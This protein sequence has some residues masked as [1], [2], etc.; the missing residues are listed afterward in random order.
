M[1]APRDR[2]P[3]VS[4]GE[5]R[6]RVESELSGS[7]LGTALSSTGSEGFAVEPLFTDEHPSRSKSPQL[8]LAESLR[9]FPRPRGAAPGGADAPNREICQFYGHDDPTEVNRRLREGLDGGATGAWLR[10]GTGDTTVSSLRDFRVAT[11]GLPVEPTLWM[12]SVE[13]DLGAAASLALEA[14]V[15]RLGERGESSVVLRADPVQISVNAALSSPVPTS[16]EAELARIVGRFAD[17][18]PGSRSIVVSSPRLEPG[19]SDLVRELGVGI[20]AVA[21]YLDRMVAQGLD[22]ALT[23]RQ[24][25]WTLAMGREIFPEIAKLRAA[26]VLWRQL[27][28]SRGVVSPSRPWLHAVCGVGGPDPKPEAW[29]HL[30][31]GTTAAFAAIAGGADA[32]TTLPFED[33]GTSSQDRWARNTQLIL[34]EESFL[35]EVLDPGGGSYYLDWLTAELAERAW[36]N[37]LEIE[38]HGGIE[39]FFRESR[40]L[41]DLP[42]LRKRA[43]HGKTPIDEDDDI[44]QM[45]ALPIESVDVV[46]APTPE[47]ISRLPVYSSQDLEG[48]PYTDTMPGFAPFIR[49]PYPTMY[50]GRP[51]TIRQYAGFSTAEASNAFYRRNLAGGQKGLSIAFDL[52]THRGYDS[53]HPRVAGDVGMAGVAI[54]SILDMRILF[55]GIPLDKM[56]VSMTMNGAVLPVMALYIVAAEEQGVSADQLSGTIQNDILKEFMVRNTYIYPPEQSM[57]IVRDIIAFSAEHMPRFNS[58]SISGYHMQEAGA[59]ADLELAYTLADGLE[60]VRTGLGAGLGIDEFAPRLSFFFGIGMDYFMEVA[61][62]RA[63]RLLWAELIQ[64]FEPRDSRSLMLRTHCQTSGWSLSA[65]DVFNNVSRTCIE[66][67]AAVHGQTQSL[68]TNSFDEA[69]ALPTDFSARIARDTQI[70]LQEESGVCRVIDPWGGS[71]YVE[72]LT[73]QIAERARE[74]IAEVE[75]MGGMVKAIEAGLPKLRIEEAA[76]R[77]QA[78]IDSGRQSIVGVNRYRVEETEPVEVLTVDNESARQIQIERLKKLRSERDP[79]EV[80]AALRS[81]TEGAKSADANLLALAVAAV[82]ARATVGEVSLA[83]EGVF[84]RHR[85]A[86][87]AVGGVYSKEMGE[88]RSDVEAVRRRVERFLAREGRRPRILVAKIG[89]D[90]HDRGQKVISSGFSDLGFD[91]DIGPLFQT[92]EEVARQAVENDVHVVGV[93][94]LAAGHSSLVPELCK[95]LGNLHRADILVV[96]G[97]VVP[98]KDHRAL[99]ASGARAVFGP[100]TP[101][102]VAALDLLDHLESAAGGGETS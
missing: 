66:A 100:G 86:T 80:E 41:R 75:D 59:S 28:H 15:E 60:Y 8:D 91:V 58:V 101:I 93:S 68:H 11:E 87:H 10:L 82:R 22:P 5:W 48:V 30:L 61:K 49:G 92:P 7:D 24:I 65:R 26:R 18:F 64:P 42:D 25:G 55:E 71:Y 84:G 98:E 102:P 46:S 40:S 17:R 2:F 51:W 78:R 9:A 88:G 29:T 37:H 63:A 62:L 3:P 27:L 14:M 97:G 23:A 1:G 43:D 67:M 53:D 85:P 36:A 79:G 76:A 81:L 69:L 73:H 44:V 32:I 39:R 12:F 70:L 57:R 77:T 4:Y 13:G 54:D 35:E 21:D 31:R 47:G 52:P 50:V 20:A 38:R 34:A 96:V 33:M 45:G 74:L 90:G 56:S 89:Q 99:F 72:K 83:L 94:S 19:G 16:T 6:R 95:E